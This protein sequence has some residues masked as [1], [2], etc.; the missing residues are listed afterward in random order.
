M[1]QAGLPL[2]HEGSQ[3]KVQVFRYQSYPAPPQQVTPSWN[4]HRSHLPGTPPRSHLPGPPHRSH[5]GNHAPSQVTP[6]LAPLAG[7]ASWD[8]P[9]TGHT[10]L[11]KPC[12]NR[13]HLPGTPPLRSHLPGG[14]PHRSHLWEPCPHTGLT[15]GNHAPPTSLTFLG[16]PRSADTER[17]NT[18][19]SKSVVRY[20]F[21]K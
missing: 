20:D 16:H 2:C 19:R 13:S 18:C 7:H 8:P 4:P 6:S 5:L 15:S 14:P 11:G 21:C 3:L 12:L 17:W 1:R 10:L 9:H